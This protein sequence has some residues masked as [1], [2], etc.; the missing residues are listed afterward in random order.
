MIPVTEAEKRILEAVTVPQT[1]ESIPLDRAGGRILAAAI[2][3]PLPFPH[4]DNSA[5]DGY[6]VRFA[7]VAQVP[8][9]LTV[10]QEIPAGT[11]PQA[12]LQPGEAA[13]IFTGA[14][15]PPGAD[16]IVIQEVTDRQGDRVTIKER[17]QPGEFVR[18][19]GEF[20]SAGSP[21]LATGM[22]LNPAA[23]AVA[24]ATGIDRVA[25]YPR[26]RVVILATGDELVPPGQRPGPGQIV[27]S[28]SLAIATFVRQLGLEPLGLG[29]APDDRQ[30]L[31]SQMLR[32]LELGDFILSTGGVSVG[33][34]DHVEVLLGELGGEI[35]LNQVAIKPGKPLTVA[36]FAS[37]AL[38]FGIPGNPVSALVCGWRFV[39]AA[40]RK[41]QGYAAPWS[42]PTVQGITTDK[43]KGAIR[44][45]TYL[46]GQC[47]W[48]EQGYQFRLV[49]G[50]HSSG[51]LINLAQANALAVV[52]LGME[53]IA[54]GSP[55]TIYPIS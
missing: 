40:L 36:K 6:G 1:P 29:I 18:R 50:G 37:G 55:I 31:R 2:A 12:P 53:A 26:P 4:W 19:R 22:V 3:S 34:Y 5:M 27:D 7:D 43:L 32:A 33:E 28:N 11:V 24:A 52:P 45:E 16:T 51:N 14:M 23:I 21:L 39:G 54:P 17:P 20:H 38:F 13:R 48:T 42:P 8:V 9:T 49:P 25:V 44:R 10:S 46:W 41:A 35:L 15:L 30:T 47:Q